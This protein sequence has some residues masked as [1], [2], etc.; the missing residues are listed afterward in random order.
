[1]KNAITKKQI[2]TFEEAG[3]LVLRNFLTEGQIDELLRLA[4]QQLAQSIEPVE[5]ETDVMYPGS[6]ESI[7][8][9]GGRTI[10]RMLGAYQRSDLFRTVAK[11]QGIKSIL[12]ILLGSSA[13][14]MSQCHHN[15]IMTKHPDYS[16][17]T[18]WHQDNRY[19]QFEQQNLI[20][21]WTALGNEREEN[22]CLRVIPESH[23]LKITDSQLDE[24]L[25]LN[26]ELPENQKLIA[27][28]RLVE[29]NKG[30]VLLFHS[31]LFHAAGRNHSDRIK[32][33]LVFTYHELTNHPIKNSK[34]DRLPSIAL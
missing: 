4:Q 34:S 21:A 26:T 23:R 33:S 11:S 10:R 6:P 7:T 5:Y 3:F 2:Q 22:G 17:S 9:T 24:K 32:Y 20:T 30:D 15:C 12:N 16:S 18:D 1:M 13:V 19:W 31:R 14:A 29:L 25:F 27:T 8:A 28:N